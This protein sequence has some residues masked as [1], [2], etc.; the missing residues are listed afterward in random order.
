[1]LCFTIFD[2]LTYN[3]LVIWSPRFRKHINI[4]EAV[5]HRATRMIP[6]VT[7][8]TYRQRLTKLNLYSLAFR[9]RG[10]DP[11]FLNHKLN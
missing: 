5:P 7:D 2:I 4:I 6:T 8:Y 10:F 1:M 3:K 11:G 9:R